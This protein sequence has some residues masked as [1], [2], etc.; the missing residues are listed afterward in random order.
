M[1]QLS[2]DP[3]S[4]LELLVARHRLAPLGEPVTRG[5]LEEE[6]GGG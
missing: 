2:Q 1:G 6:A 4:P 3:L 5:C